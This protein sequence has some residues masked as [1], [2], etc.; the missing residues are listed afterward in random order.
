MRVVVRGDQLGG[1]SLPTF[2]QTLSLLYDNTP[3]S[4]DQLSPFAAGLEWLFANYA[5]MHKASAVAQYLRTERTLNRR[6]I[7]E[8]LGETLQAFNM[9]VLESYV[10]GFDFTGIPFAR[11]LRMFLTTFHLPGEAQKIER[12]VEAFAAQFHACN[13]QVFAHEV[14]LS[15]VWRRGWACATGP[16]GLDFFSL[17]PGTHPLSFP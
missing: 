2:L 8:L 17:C 7:G 3:A 13:R 9:D 12:I 15:R 14:G 1:Q 5:V 6:K 10:S 4:P 16:G 11:A